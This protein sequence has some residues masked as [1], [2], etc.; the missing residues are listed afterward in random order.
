MQQEKID[1]IN[2]LYH[3]AIRMSL[4]GNLNSISIQEE[5]G[6]ITDLGKKHGNVGQE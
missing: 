5:D 3:K 6:T 1:R 2:T 4:R